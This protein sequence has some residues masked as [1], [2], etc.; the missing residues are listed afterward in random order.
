MPTSETDA[1]LRLSLDQARQSFVLE[2]ATENSR[3]LTWAFDLVVQGYLSLSSQVL[4]PEEV[5][6]DVCDDAYHRGGVAR[7]LV[8]TGCHPETGDREPLGTVRVTTGAPNNDLGLPPLETMGLMAP[9]EGWQNFHFEGFDAAR[10]AEGGRLAVSPTCRIGK[11]RE[12]G[13]TPIV[14]KALVEGGFRYAAERYGKTQYW[15]VLPY[16]VIERFVA[17]GFRVIPAPG[18]TCRLRENARIFSRYDRYWQ[19]SRP[20]FCKV[21]LPSL[22][23]G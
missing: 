8:L 3:L 23:S 22:M 5:R 21:V 16:Y 19:Q 17:L 20:I 2:D 4:D 18:V 12:I 6:Q 9:P 15:G 13:L 7:T 10:V 1:N 14:L 11:S